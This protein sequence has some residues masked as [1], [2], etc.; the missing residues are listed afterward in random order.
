MD[1]IDIQKKKYLF[2]SEPVS[3]I[4][5]YTI[6]SDGLLTIRPYMCAVSELSSFELNKNIFAYQVRLVPISIQANG[7]KTYTGAV[8]IFFFCDE[9]GDGKFETRYHGS[10]TLDLLKVPTWVKHNQKNVKPGK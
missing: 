7:K 9:D 2:S 6:S 8:F 3:L 5:L 10:Q 1:G 4:E